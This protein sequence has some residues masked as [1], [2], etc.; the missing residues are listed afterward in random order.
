[1]TRRR[2]Q[3]VG[4]DTTDDVDGIAREAG[5][6]GEVRAVAKRDGSGVD[7]E[8]AA[9]QGRAVG[10][11][12]TVGERGRLERVFVQVEATSQRQGRILERGGPA[13]GDERVADDCAAVVPKRDAA[14]PSVGGLDGLAGHAAP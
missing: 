10:D 3:D 12:R 8:R 13:A 5:M 11:L 1:M 9:L 6:P 4:D 2:G 14:T 7:P